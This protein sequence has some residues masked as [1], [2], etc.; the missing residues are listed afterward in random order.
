MV[1]NKAKLAELLGETKAPVEKVVKEKKPRTEKQIAA[2]EKL[3]E[4]NAAKREAAKQALDDEIKQKETEKV[5]A[6]AKLAAAEAKKLA[7]AE[8]RKRKKE[9]V[10]MDA[11][12]DAAVAGTEE[13]VKLKKRAVSGNAQLKAW[14]EGKVT[15]ILTG[16]DEIKKL[17]RQPAE[18]EKEARKIV[19]EKFKDPESR[20][21][22]QSISD[23]HLGKLTTMIFPQ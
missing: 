4:R 16:V 1:M 12:I 2:A 10:S 21:Q 23:D 14:F 15:E 3:K 8:A 11:A 5:D 20:A 18:I 13:P 17:G 19:K 9:E 6:E 7:R 22:V